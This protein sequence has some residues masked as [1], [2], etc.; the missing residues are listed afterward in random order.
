MLDP[1]SP[2][3]TICS[4][5]ILSYRTQRSEFQT[6]TAGKFKRTL[7]PTKRVTKLDLEKSKEDLEQVLTQFAGFVKEN[8]PALDMDSVATGETWFGNAALEKGLCD[9]IQT[10]DD[11]LLGYVDRGFDVYE[12]D[13]S[14]PA[15]VPAGLAQLLPSTSGASRDSNSWPRKAIRWMVNM[16]ADEVRAAVAEQTSVENRYMAKDETSKRLQMR[17]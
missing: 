6:V 7:T 17:D 16:V 9:E 14:P 11:L 3:P 15:E 2:S 1:V 4:N 10:V 5:L 8:R 12:I 13:Y